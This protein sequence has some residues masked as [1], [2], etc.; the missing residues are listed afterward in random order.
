MEDLRL[1][2]GVVG[3]LTMVLREGGGAA[4]VRSKEECVQDEQRVSS[5]SAV[6]EVGANDYHKHTTSGMNDYSQEHTGG[7]CR[8]R[9][10]WVSLAWGQTKA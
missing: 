4:R 6:A 2:E 7:D 9:V 1:F 3:V 5:R 8:Q 10:V